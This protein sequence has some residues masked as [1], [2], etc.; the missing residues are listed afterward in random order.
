LPFTVSF[1]RF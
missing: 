1:A